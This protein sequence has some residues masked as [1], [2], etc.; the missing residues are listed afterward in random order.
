MAGTLARRFPL[1]KPIASSSL[2][3]ASQSD[4]GVRPVPTPVA[5][6]APTNTA[7]SIG[8][9]E[10]APTP[11]VV[12]VEGGNAIGNTPRLPD[13]SRSRECGSRGREAGSVREGLGLLV[14]LEPS[15]AWLVFEHALSAL[16]VLKRG[17]TRTCGAP[18]PDTRRFE[19]CCGDKRG[20]NLARVEGE[21]GPSNDDLEGE[22]EEVLKS[23]GRV[24]GNGY[25]NRELGPAAVAKGVPTNRAGGE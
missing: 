3:S 24:A 19:C 8:P 7:G 12:M 23:A 6:V 18:P 5:A 9:A 15:P 13:R 4:P 10:G 14:E 16:S 1:C 11:T 22:I 20:I 2:S 21:G 17:G 25:S